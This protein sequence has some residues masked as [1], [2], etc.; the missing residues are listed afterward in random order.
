MVVTL[1]RTLP[2]TIGVVGK[3]VQVP[4]QTVAPLVPPDPVPFEFPDP[5]LAPFPDMVAPDLTPAHPTA[6][7]SETPRSKRLA[8]VIRL[9][10]L[11]NFTCR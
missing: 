6:P 1:E 4:L 9:T 2:S 5:L 11:A 3:S 7:R 10:S 8:S